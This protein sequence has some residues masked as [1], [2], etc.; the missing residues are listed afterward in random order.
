MRPVCTDSQPSVTKEISDLGIRISIG[1]NSKVPGPVTTTTVLET[2]DMLVYKG[3]NMSGTDEFDSVVSDRIVDEIGFEDVV[4]DLGNLEVKNREKP[5]EL[6]YRRV[7]LKD[8]SEEPANTEENKEL[9]RQSKKF[10]ADEHTQI[11]VQA[12]VDGVDGAEGSSDLK[13]LVKK[14]R[15]DAALLT[16]NNSGGVIAEESLHSD[17]LDFVEANFHQSEGLETVFN[18]GIISM[19]DV[20]SRIHLAIEIG[21]VTLDA[22]Y[23]PE[24]IMIF[25]SSKV[26]PKILNSIGKEL[27]RSH[28][29]MMIVAN[30]S[31][32]VIE[33]KVE[34][35]LTIEEVTRLCE[36]RFA[37]HLDTEMILELGAQAEFDMYFGSWL[38]KV[39]M[40]D[41]SERHN[42]LK[43]WLVEEEGS[44]AIAD[45]SDDEQ[46]RLR[47][48][49]DMLVP[50]KQ[51][52]EV[53]KEAHSEP[54]EGHLGVEKTYHRLSLRYY[55][56]GIYADVAKF[57][58]HAA[59]A[60]GPWSNRT[61]RLA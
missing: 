21:S 3:M 7:D 6:P 16:P 12:Q 38:K 34:L 61:D 11:T 10:V 33:G 9:W 56:P 52:L 59:P 32:Q 5:R 31:M 42:P 51:R 14:T 48:L 24:S 8:D 36:V 49:V 22:L 2:I 20:L 57:V 18:S 35:P 1:C 47:E 55:W 41:A 15:L 26:G 53:L 58:R 39:F 45:F 28:R 60:R 37:E 54:Q 44:S 13:T 23:D 46:V 27:D 30:G 29:S 43:T 17:S 40:P 50:E 25:V 19:D 4:M